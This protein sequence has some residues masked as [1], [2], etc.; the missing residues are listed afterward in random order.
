MKLSTLYQSCTTLARAMPPKK[1]KSN[2]YL[3]QIVEMKRQREAG[4]QQDSLEEGGVNGGNKVKTTL[5]YLKKGISAYNF[6]KIHCFDNLSNVS[7]HI[8]SQ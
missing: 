3:V 4:G 6:C 1:R 5:Y 8:N 2:D 7:F